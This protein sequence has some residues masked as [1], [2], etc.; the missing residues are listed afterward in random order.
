MPDEEIFAKAARES[1]T[2]LTFDLGFSELVALSGQSTVSAV[3]FRLANARSD[4]VIRR[5]NRV[6]EESADEL[7]H[8]AIITVEEERHRVRL[9]PIGRR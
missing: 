1:R 6:L 2:I 4:N 9:L 3:V 5:V 7:E 8:G